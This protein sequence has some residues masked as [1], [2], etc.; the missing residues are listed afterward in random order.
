MAKPMILTDDTQPT[1]FTFA[2]QVGVQTNESVSAENPVP[3]ELG[4]TIESHLWL[5]NLEMSTGITPT[6]STTSKM[7]REPHPD[8][9]TTMTWTQ[10][11]HEQNALERACML[12]MMYPGC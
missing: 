7:P 9:P 5:A 12:I 6:M 2:N 3:D 4:R 8:G 1:H 10:L 11:A